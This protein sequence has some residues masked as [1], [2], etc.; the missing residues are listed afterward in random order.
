MQTDGQNF[1]DCVNL[2]EVAMKTRTESVLENPVLLRAHD[3]ADPPPR[4]FN[5]LSRHGPALTC[6]TIYS[7]LLEESGRCEVCTRDLY[8]D[9]LSSDFTFQEILKETRASLDSAHLTNYFLQVQRKVEEGWQEFGWKNC[10]REEIFKV[11]ISWLTCAD[12]T[13]M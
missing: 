6:G 1:N 3:L 10:L 5:K 8:T 2:S 7:K 13:D 11:P 12:H 9:I 4:P